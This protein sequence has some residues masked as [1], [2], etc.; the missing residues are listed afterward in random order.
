LSVLVE[1]VH[2]VAVGSPVA[3][4]GIV[5]AHLNGEQL[6][7]GGFEGDVVA[8]G[9]GDSHQNAVARFTGAGGE[10][11]LAGG[12]GPRPF[13]ELEPRVVATS[14][15]GAGQCIVRLSRGRMG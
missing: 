11:A 1:C 5:S 12:P 7:V 4:S 2:T 9:G 6:P 13:G 3:R 15:S 8:F 14:R 10:E